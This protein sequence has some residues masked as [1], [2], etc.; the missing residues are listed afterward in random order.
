MSIATVRP[1]ANRHT[2]RQTHTHPHA[3]KEK[4]NVS[5]P[6]KNDSTTSQMLSSKNPWREFLRVNLGDTNS[7]QLSSAEEDEIGD[8]Y[9]VGHRKEEE[10]AK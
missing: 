1:Y 9:K 7:C 6:L 10:T 8:K 5:N 4:Q 2:H 3:Q